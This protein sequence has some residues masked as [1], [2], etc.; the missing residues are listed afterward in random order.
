[1]KLKGKPVRLRHSR[2]PGDARVDVW[3]EVTCAQER[4]QETD[5]NV[6]VQE[7]ASASS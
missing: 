3:R 4:Y 6:V 7:L 1:M 5:Q 2:F